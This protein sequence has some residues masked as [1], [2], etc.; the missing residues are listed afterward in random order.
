MSAPRAT[1]HAVEAQGIFRPR[2][3]LSQ[4]SGGELPGDGREP[5][6]R[7]PGNSSAPLHGSIA[8]TSTRKDLSIIAPK[9][10]WYTQAPQEIHLEG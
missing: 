4:L 6:R 2:Y 1:S 8:I 9:G 5:R 3:H 10:H 7:T